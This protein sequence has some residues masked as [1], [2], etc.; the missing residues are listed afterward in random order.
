MKRMVEAPVAQG[1]EGSNTERSAA[2]DGGAR[3][4]FAVIF[5]VALDA[6]GPREQ[7]L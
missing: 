4:A 7:A 3:G 6:P 5:A 1:G 2:F